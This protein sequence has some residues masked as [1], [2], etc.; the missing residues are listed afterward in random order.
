M[1]DIIARLRDIA[2]YDSCLSN[3]DKRVLV[4]ASNELETAMHLIDEIHEAIY[5]TYINLD[6]EEELDA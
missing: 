4:K 6:D 5:R 3:D 2:A 1:M